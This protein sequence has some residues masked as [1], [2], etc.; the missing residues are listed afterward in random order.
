MLTTYFEEKLKFIDCLMTIEE[1]IFK[2]EIVPILIAA[3]E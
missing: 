3:N 1:E 2:R